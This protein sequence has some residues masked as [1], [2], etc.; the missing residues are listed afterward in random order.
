MNDEG[1]EC[2]VLIVQ[3]AWNFDQ[4]PFV[5]RTVHCQDVYK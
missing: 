4:S 5:L 3:K 2:N 1:E